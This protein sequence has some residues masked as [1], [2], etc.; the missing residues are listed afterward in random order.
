MDKNS[1]E[2]SNKGSSDKDFGKE[3]NHNEDSKDISTPKKDSPLGLMSA[4]HIYSLITNAIKALLGERGLRTNFYIKP[5]MKRIDMLCI[6]HGYQ[7][8]KFNQFNV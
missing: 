6:P 8:L 4:K 2:A 3:S 1:L 7:L 5:H